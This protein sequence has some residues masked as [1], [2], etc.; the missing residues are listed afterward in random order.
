MTS[1][2]NDRVAAQRAILRAVNSITWSTEPLLGLSRKAIDRWISLNKIDAHSHIAEL[3]TSVAS[4][5]F[6]LANKS[7]D[8]M[9][10]EYQL[11]RSE[12][13]EARD[14]IVR[15]LALPIV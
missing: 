13:I 2:F 12:I 8:Q 14:D 7:Q 5:L 9:S 11:V 15:K 1:E 6:F 4:K 10:D 3:V